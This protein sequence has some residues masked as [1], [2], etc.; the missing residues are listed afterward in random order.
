MSTWT[1]RRALAAVFALAACVPGAGLVPAGATRAVSVLGGAVTVAGPAGYCVDKGPSRDGEAGAFVLFGTCAALTGSPAAGEPAYPAILT[2]TVLPGAPGG[3]FEESFA[4]M[5]AFFRSGPGRAALSR[6]G[7]ADDVRLA[8]V[9]SRDRVLYLRLEDSSAVAGQRVEPDYW[10]A[11]LQ[12]RGR[13]VTLSAL[14]LKSRPV[15]AAEK[16]RVLDAFVAR[17]RSA[18]AARG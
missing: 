8:Q 10:R 1:S 18:N 2:A 3:T 13:I 15:P 14:G 17:V 6:S 16:R 7:R 4:A 11:I 12:V 9:L 5:A